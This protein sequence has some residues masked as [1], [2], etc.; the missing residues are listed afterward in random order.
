MSESLKED[1]YA[2]FKSAMDGLLQAQS[3]VDFVQS[4]LITKYGLKDGDRIEL[5][6]KIV[7][8]DD[9]LS[10]LPDEVKECLIPNP[11]N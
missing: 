1:D 2:Y 6:G 10:N 8:M 11:V 4:I 7:R 9:S 5:D 3:I